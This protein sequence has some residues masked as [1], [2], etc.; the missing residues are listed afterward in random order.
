MTAPLFD[1]LCGPPRRIEGRRSLSGAALPA[2]RAALWR[3]ALGV[4][5][6]LALSQAP[7]L[8]IPPLVSGDVSTAEKGR[9]ELFV[10]YLFNDA[11]DAREH[12]IIS[13]SNAHDPQTVDLAA[14]F[15]AR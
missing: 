3:H 14:D 13:R 9:Y 7:A 6:L 2:P 11:G 8:A 10:G 1:A 12:Q 4:V 15:H 5:C